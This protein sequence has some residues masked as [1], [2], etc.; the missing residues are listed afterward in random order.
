M[1]GLGYLGWTGLDCSV[2]CLFVVNIG[3][4]HCVGLAVATMEA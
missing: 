1:V 3:S 4:I 2:V